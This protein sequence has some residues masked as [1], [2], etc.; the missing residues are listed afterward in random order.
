[1]KNIDIDEL[2]SRVS[3]VDVIA[4]DVDLRER[5]KD[6]IARCPFH[7]EKT[8]SFK[9][10]NEKGIFHCFGC[11]AGGDVIEFIRLYHGLG[12]I[13]SVQMLAS[14]IGMSVDDSL[15]ESDEYKM[16]KA[17]EK[18]MNL[19]RGTKKSEIDSFLKS[20]ALDLSLGE[21]FSMGVAPKGRKILST[22]Y[23]SMTEVM[24]ESGMIMDS[25]LDRFYNRI[26]FPIIHQRH[27]IG[28]GGR[29]IGSGHTP[30]YINSM[31][32]KIYNKSEVLFGLN[33]AKPVMRKVKAAYV[34]EGYTDVLSFHQ[35]GIENVVSPCGTSFTKKQAS[36]VKRFADTI[37]LVYD[38]DSAGKRAGFSAMRTAMNV[39]M[40]VMF[41]LLPEGEDPNS[42]L[43]KVGSDVF[44][45]VAKKTIGFCEYYG[46]MMRGKTLRSR[47]RLVRELQSIADT[48]PDATAR[49]LTQQEIAEHFD[50]E[51]K[52]G[53]PASKMVDPPV[54]TLE[55]RMLTGILEGGNV[56]AVVMSDIKREDIVAY[57]DLFDY[58]LLRYAE[59]GESPDEPDLISKFGDK[60]RGIIAS[61][62]L[63]PARVTVAS[64][65]VIMAATRAR[66]LMSEIDKMA[67]RIGILEDKGEDT[68]DLREK[69][70]D[71][72]KQRRKI[73][74]QKKII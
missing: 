10:S 4:R 5:G 63:H 70:D 33:F 71:L 7:T 55:F 38:E 22:K 53:K 72:E 46:L 12:F 30:K 48:I 62:A 44:I 17:N 52:R 64:M 60:Y 57:R 65:E 9:V 43:L 36:I 40:T 58:I 50:V 15:E 61:A 8:A 14:I 20:R 31:N 24:V 16:L 25:G 51:R 49:G 59:T 69:R 54:R 47:I 32:S 18:A 23:P 2:K 3:I 19:Y 21:K 66:S 6:W 68:I 13:E 45:D 56:A 1:M 34:V 35:V 28:F 42:F 41:M 67:E 29:R 27:P 74:N 26:I 39:G 11:K 73:L 37:I